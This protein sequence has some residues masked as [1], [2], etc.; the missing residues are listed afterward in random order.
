M[1]DT[2]PLNVCIYSVY[3]AQYM[4]KGSDIQ[5]THF[6][7]LWNGYLYIYSIQIYPKGQFKVGP[8]NSWLQI[9]FTEVT[10]RVALK[11]KGAW[12]TSISKIDRVSLYIQMYW[13]CNTL[14]NFRHQYTPK[15]PENK[16]RYGA[17]NVFRLCLLKWTIIH[18]I[19]C[20]SRTVYAGIV[21][22]I[23]WH[24]ASHSLQF[25]AIVRC[26]HADW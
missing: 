8:L 11:D 19:D 9:A 5:Y 4:G 26:S 17:C 14:Y 22:D 6:C 16:C 24:S 25:V 10:G 7:F 15:R 20:L 1:A 2:A 21:C 13:S 3:T 12:I 18:Q 23:C